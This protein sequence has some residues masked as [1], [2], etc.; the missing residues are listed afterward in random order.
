MRFRDEIVLH[1]RGGDGGD[2]GVSFL[3][4]KFTP[5]G[6]PA[7]GRGGDGGN[8]HLRVDASLNTL[9][10]LT[11]IP[12]YRAGSG[13]PGGPKHQAGKR[14][15]DLVLHVPCGT[16]VR[17]VQTN[18][19]VADLNQDQESVLIAR[20]GKGGLGNA[21]FATATRQA[22][23]YAEKGKPGEDRRLALE[24]KLIADVGIVGL[25][26]AGK[27][28]LLAAISRAHPKIASYPFTTLT[29]SLG[30]VGTDP[31][32]TFVVADLP[33]LI[34]GASKGA[35]L[36]DRFLRHVERTRLILHVVDVSSDAPIAPERAYRVVREEL[37]AFN[38]QLASKP[39]V[40]AANKMDLPGAEGGRRKLARACGRSV[41]GIAARD[42]RGLTALVRRL[43]KELAGRIDKGAP[44]R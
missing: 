21:S 10:H 15:R 35:G 24:L 13:A 7:G 39:E 20:G 14:G 28:T 32:A 17:D 2:G 43:L 27:S 6:G 22:P 9:H 37:A 23:R 42:R 40:V 38:P 34:E 33:G 30:V 44:G 18:K 26:N 19:L 4:E 29:P 41:A 36:G 5:R 8:L 1:V 3:R 16:V 11:G 12:L 31:L 25:P